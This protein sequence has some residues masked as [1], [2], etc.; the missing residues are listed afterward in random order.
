MKGKLGAF[1]LLSDDIRAVL[2]EVGIE[3]ETRPQEDAIPPILD[4]KNTLVIAPTGIGKTEA[5]FLPILDKILSEDREGFSLLY[6]TPLK[7]LNRDMIRRIQ[8]FSDRLDFR[9][10]VRHGDTS[11]KERRKQAENPPEVL[12]TTPE[13]LQIMFTGHKLRKGLKNV[14]HVVVDELNELAED[15]RGSQLSLALERLA[16]L[17]GNDFQRVGLSATVGSPEKVK[18]FLVGMG[19]DGIIIETTGKREL[20]IKV[21]KPVQR[22]DKDKKLAEM[23]RCDIEKASSLRLCRELIE[24]HTSTLFFVNT[25]DTAESL[26]SSYTLWKEE[27]PEITDFPIGVHHGSL[28]KDARI[29]MEERFKKGELKGLICT[30]SMELG[31]DVGK[32]DLVLQYQ[33]PRQVTRLIQRVGRSGHK[34]NEIS[35]GRIISTTKDDILE[36]VVIS[37]RGKIRNLE[38]T[39]IPEQPLSVLANQLISTVHTEKE[40]E[41]DKFFKLAKRS[42]PFK[43]LEKESFDD[44]IEQL[45]EIRVIWKEGDKIGKRRA[46]LNYFYNNISMIPDEKTYLL[47]NFSSDSVIGTL[48]ESFVASNIQEGEVI[49]L[50]GKAWRVVD[51][52]E[53]EVLVDKVGNIGKIPD[54]TGEDIPVPF[55]V[56]QE[57]G[58]LRRND[59]NIQL[60]EY[61][62]SESA[63]EAYEEYLESQ[64]DHEIPTDSKIVIEVEKE[65]AVVNACF[66]T[67]VNETLGHVFASLLSARLGESVG[68]QTDPYRIMM[69]LPRRIDTSMIKDILFE[70]RAESLEELMEKSLRSSNFFNWKFLH[71]GKKFGAIEKDADWRKINMDKIIDTF[72]DTI[73]YREAVKKTFRDNMDIDQTKNIL[74][75]I[76]EGEIDVVISEKGISPIG[77]AGLEKHEEFLSPDRVSKAVLDSLKERLESE[78]VIMK[79]LRCGNRRRKRVRDVKKP[80]CPQC[81]SSMVAPLRP[82]DDETLVDKENDELT[83]DEKKELKKYYKLAEL[84]RVHKKRAVMALSARGIGHQKAGRI[85]SK[86]HLEEENFLRDVLEGEIEYARTKRFWD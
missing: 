77:K 31:I 58:R 25:R 70:T 60:N 19:R 21:E 38:K 67:L 83:K 10:G 15:E 44:L 71:V 32:T 40:I 57:V 42:Y 22:E 65:T 84:A 17:C 18:D 55:E 5:A 76:D 48:D 36:G 46:S 20:D 28:S 24:D 43:L 39:D 78:K 29:E 45:A 41:P 59:T 11:R 49:T 61:P 85:L 23:M 73:L 9:V 64:Q 6:I 8:E 30:S 1:D 66:G 74:K 51:M 63:K 26:S 3:E 75:E 13:T 27:D 37:K 4:G 47:R 86:R 53:E 16:E 69:N 82:Y 79:C 81:G 56:A 2:S 52:K 7:A 72:E 54:W 80:S 68:L 14:R 34:I 62:I 35:K 12:I 33:S 50:Q